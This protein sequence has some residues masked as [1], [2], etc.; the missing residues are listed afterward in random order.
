MSR[1]SQFFVGAASIALLPGLAHAQEGDRYGDVETLIVSDF[2]GTVKIKTGGG[3]VTVRKTDGA[4]A[5]YPFFVENENGRLT[6]RSDEDP[7]E[8]RWRDNVDWRRFEANAFDKFLEAYPVLEITAPSGTALLFD[9][10]VIRLAADDTRGALEVRRGHVDGAVGN[11]SS[12][13]IEI[14]GSGDLTLGDVSGA[15]DV[16]IHGSGDLE[17]GDVGTLVASIH[18]SGDIHAGDVADEAEARIHGSGDIE[19]GDIG[20]KITISVHGS[21]DVKTAHVN[22]GAKLSTMGS[23]DLHLASVGGETDVKIQGNG[24]ID[25]D[26]GRA[27]NLTVRIHGSGDFS[28]LGRATNPDVSVHGS[29]SVRIKDHDGLVRTRGRGDIRISGVNY[30]DDD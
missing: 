28:F 25:I 2:I 7:D 4:D 10:A 9:S 20:G 18:G 8:T 26:G 6:L 27:E 13:E 29:G 5:S 16:D 24:D 30:N 1:F 17:A 21:G 14:H 23:G 11:I 3:A 12:G 15:L 19:L 22:E